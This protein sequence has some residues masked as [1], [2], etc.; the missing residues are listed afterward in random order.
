MLSKRS[1]SLFSRV[2]TMTGMTISWIWVKISGELSTEEMMV[3]MVF[4]TPMAAKVLSSSTSLR[5]VSSSAFSSM[6]SCTAL[7]RARRMYDSHW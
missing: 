1:R 4:A 7:S 3:L 5:R 2:K 6:W